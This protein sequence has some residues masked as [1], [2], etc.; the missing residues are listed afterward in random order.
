MADARALLP[1]AVVLPHEPGRDATTLEHLALWAERFSPVVESAGAEAL[2]LDVSGCGRVFRGE[3][4]IARQAVAGLAERGIRARAAI[5]ETVGAAWALAHGAAEPIVVAPQGEAVPRLVGLPVSVLRLEAKTVETLDAI[6]IR[7][8]GDLL[9]LPRATLPSRFGE[10]L[11]LRLRQVLGEVPEWV[12]ARRRSRV[13]SARMAFGPTDR[14]EAV[15]A[16]L[17]RTTAVLCEQLIAGG[18]AAR[19]LLLVV[20]FEGQ[21]PVSAWVG[22]SRPSRDAKHLRGLLDARVEWVDVSA[23]TTGLMVTATEVAGWRPSQ[24]DLFEAGG[25]SDDEAVGALVDRLAGRLGDGAVVRAEAVDDYQPEKAVRY[26]PLTGRRGDNAGTAVPQVPQFP[27]ASTRSGRLWDR[28][29]DPAGG[30]AGER[31]LVLFA[32]PREIRVMSVAPDGPPAW[33]RYEGREYV[34]SAVAGP[35][36]LETGWWRGADVRRDYFRV[37]TE[38]GQQFW[39]FRELK[40]QTWYVHGVYE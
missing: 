15:T 39:V 36:R 3:G 10:G 29:H 26:V 40:T 8:I 28:T 34:V 11:V 19:R 4:N 6:G 35:E 24:G 5:A 22:L 18:A 38:G 37:T 30:P 21:A 1:E 20:Y 32:R 16:A 25:R 2:L 12:S 14:R 27:H 13:Y 31:P 7:K 17:E 9:M 33:L 23:G